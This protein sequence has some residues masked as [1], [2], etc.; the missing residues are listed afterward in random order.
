MSQLPIQ[1]QI[2]ILRHAIAE[3]H[4]DVEKLKFDVEAIEYKEK[5]SKLW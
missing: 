2:D 5:R 1:K 4:H 3:L